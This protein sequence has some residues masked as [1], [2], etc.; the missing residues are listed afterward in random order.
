[1][2]RP[3]A[4]FLCLLVT[5]SAFLVA[6]CGNDQPDAA[7]LEAARKEGAREARAQARERRLSERVEELERQQRNQ[8]QTPAS[9]SNSNPGGQVPD[10]GTYT[11][12]GRQRSASKSSLNKDYPVE[13]SFSS[14]G[15]SISYPTLDCSGTLRPDG[16]SDGRRVYRESITSGRC[17]DG[18]T[19]LVL[20][21][22]GTRLVANW[23]IAGR[24]YTVKATLTR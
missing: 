24:D 19:W 14:S 17:D 10:S 4:L 2:F 7:A 18:G 3:T 20:V 22:S 13:M 6:G 23:S 8:G 21:V 5:A 16:F 1:M 9:P 15:S 11:G 12:V